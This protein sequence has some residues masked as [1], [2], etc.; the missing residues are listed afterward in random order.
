[1]VQEAS[2]VLLSSSLPGTASEVGGVRVIIAFR[3]NVKLL[4]EAIVG[5]HLGST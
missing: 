3:E 4:D 5:M 2:D 1:M